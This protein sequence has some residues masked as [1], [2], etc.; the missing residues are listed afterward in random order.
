MKAKDITVLFFA[1]MLS[2]AALASEKQRHVQIHVDA[3]EG[4]DAT[5]QT[6]RFDSD[7]IDFDVREL[8]LGESRSFIDKE[9]NNLFVV[10]TEEG[11]DFNVNGREIS[12]PDFTEGDV[13][14]MIMQHGDDIHGENHVI[15]GKRQIEMMTDE[16]IHIISEDM[17]LHEV[18]EIHIVREEVDVTN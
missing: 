6:F 3:Q 2:A 1:L 8:Q 12:M 10:R 11:F 4:Q 9:G 16:D 13:D 7:A 17:E 18:H 5:M 15:R 14:A